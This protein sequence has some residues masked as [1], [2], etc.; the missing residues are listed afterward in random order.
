MPRCC[1]SGW[2]AASYRADPD[3]GLTLRDCRIVNAVR[4]VP[5]ANLPEPSEVSTCNRFLASELHGLAEL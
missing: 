3:D 2:R 4:C 1:D 5:P